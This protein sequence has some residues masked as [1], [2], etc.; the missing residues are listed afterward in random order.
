VTLSERFL[1]SFIRG[2]P[3]D[4]PIDFSEIE[5]AENWYKSIE[6]TVQKFQTDQY[7]V[8][9][10]N[11]YF[12]VRLLK[13]IKKICSKVLLWSSLLARKNNSA[14][15]EASSAGLESYHNHIKTRMLQRKTADLDV[16]INIL[17]NYNRDI[18]LQ[19]EGN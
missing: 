6:S 1:S 10:N 14:N 13:Y 11:P 4:S 7:E 8:S 15:L 2:L 3:C 19:R 16:A 5:V 9:I 12:D 17:N 18:I